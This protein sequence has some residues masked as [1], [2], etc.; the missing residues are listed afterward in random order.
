MLRTT[1]MS[2]SSLSAAIFAVTWFYAVPASNA[3]AQSHSP[4]LSDQTSNVPD[5]KLDAA[6]AAIKQIATVRE[7]YEQRIRAAEPTEKERIAE[8]AKAALAKAVT[9]QGLSLPEY[10]SILVIAR[11]D[12]EVQEKILQRLGPSGK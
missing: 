7:D 12:P 8:E 3:Y 6:A 4:G 10:T 9:D 11:N 5:Q 2:T 1:R